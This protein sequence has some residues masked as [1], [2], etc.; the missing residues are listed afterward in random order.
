MCI[1]L[2]AAALVVAAVGTAVSTYGAVQQGQNAKAAAKANADYQKKA[3][4]SAENVGAQ[5]A[6]DKTLETRRVMGSQI[7]S[8]GAGGIDPN[9]GSPL[10]I[11]TQ[12]AQMGE[13]DSL[14]IINN[15]QRTAWGYQTQAG[16]DEWQGDKAATAGYFNAA[17]TALG[18][19]SNAYFGYK[20]ATK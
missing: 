14:R 7:A 17:S 10:A 1:P 6:A 2:A 5:Q 3:A 19:A 13:L 15:A 8:A 20:G 11:G 16:I 12:T 4:V 9:T 18:G